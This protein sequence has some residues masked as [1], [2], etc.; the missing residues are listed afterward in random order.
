MNGSEIPIITEGTKE[1][2][3]QNKQKNKRYRP[4]LF[5]LFCNQFPF[6]TLFPAIANQSKGLFPIYRKEDLNLS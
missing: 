5:F 6:A 1:I 4:W 2:E 3:I